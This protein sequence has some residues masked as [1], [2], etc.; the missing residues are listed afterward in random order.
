MLSF[1]SATLGFSAPAHAP[2]QPARADVRM[3][4]VAD[5][6]ALAEKLNPAVGYYNPTPLAEMEFWGQSNEA[7]IGF[8]RQAEIKHGRFAMAA[9]VGFIVQANGIKLS[10]YPY[11]TITATSPCEQWDQLPE[12]AKAQIIL[13]IGILEVFSEHSYILKD[14]GQAHYM[15]GGKPGYFPSLK[16]GFGVHP[17]PFDLFDPL[18]FSKNRI[19]EDK[20]KKLNM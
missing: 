1:A 14:Q 6:E 15:R 7:T 16:K 17:V 4:S 13:F 5:L 19:E 8:L 12:A 2:A 18:N 20:A 3:E 9:F 10:G 11:D